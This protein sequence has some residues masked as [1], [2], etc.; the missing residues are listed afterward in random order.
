MRAIEAK[1]S[2]TI[3]DTRSAMGNSIDASNPRG[4][5]WHRWDP[6]IHTPGTALNDQYKGDDPWNVFLS[7]IEQS[8]PPI[9]ALG[10]TDYC[11]IESYVET[12]AR[13]TTGR[14]AGVG[15]IFPNVEFRLSIETNKG[16]GVN[17]HLLFSPHE[18]DHVERI[19]HFLDGLMFKY[20]KETYRCNRADLMRLGRVHN[21]SLL[22][23]V[24][25]QP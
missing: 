5:A 16:A 19:R 15:L 4:S 17:L 2:S 18:A 6:H 1:Q 14:L 3:R 21:P 9:R 23:D 10:I 24:A 20:Q 12:V 8:D 22:D 7:K 25:A 13:T 11:G